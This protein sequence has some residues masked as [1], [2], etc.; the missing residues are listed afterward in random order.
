M[1]SI[2]KYGWCGTT[3]EH[4]SGTAPSP[5]S[6][7]TKGYVTYHNYYAGEPLDHVSCSNGD[8]GLIKRWGYSTIDPMAPYV[9]AVSNIEWNSPNCGKCYQ[10]VGWAKTIYVTAIDQCGPGPSG[11]MHFDIHP[12]GYRELMGAAGVTAGSGSVTYK[13][14]ASSYCKGNKG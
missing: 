6:G 11:E 7:G 10:I 12:D 8:N 4:C 14:V 5:T 9:A 2:L 1:H 13:E 3:S